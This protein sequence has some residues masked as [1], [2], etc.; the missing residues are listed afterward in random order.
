MHNIMLR[1][2]VLCG[3]CIMLARITATEIRLCWVGRFWLL[4]QCRQSVAIRLDQECYYPISW[5]ILED[6]NRDFRSTG[7][8]YL[9]DCICASSF[10]QYWESTMFF[11][12]CYCITFF[13][14]ILKLMMDS[15]EMRLCVYVGL[16]LNLH[17]RGETHRTSLWNPV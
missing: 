5:F 10:T 2:A 3:R 11:H 7:K 4:S 14:G 13:R 1:D 8:W 16:Y 17:M 6:L 9:H 15:G 12:L